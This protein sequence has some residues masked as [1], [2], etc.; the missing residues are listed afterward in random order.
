MNRN[1]CAFVKEFIH[2]PEKLKIL[3][4]QYFLARTEKVKTQ[5][6]LLKYEG[7]IDVWDK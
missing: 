4:N 2:Q 7:C 6:L 3:R 5:L 1:K